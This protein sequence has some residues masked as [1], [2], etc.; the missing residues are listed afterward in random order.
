MQI[1]LKPTDLLKDPRLRM[2]HQN[3]CIFYNSVAY[4]RDYSGLSV[5]EDEGM[6]TARQ[7][8]DK[9][10]LFMC[11]HGILVVGPTVARAF[12]YVYFLERACMFQ[13]KKL[14]HAF[15]PLYSQVEKIER[16]VLSFIHSFIHSIIHLFVRSFVH[17]FIHLSTLSSY[18][19]TH[20]PTLW[21]T[22]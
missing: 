19:L 2:Y 14:C 13:V 12:D 7:L 15:V 1:L 17:S 10:V 16:S 3:S 11:N 6:R 18:S 8:G 9:T 5:D 21:L 22:D 20:P 4:D